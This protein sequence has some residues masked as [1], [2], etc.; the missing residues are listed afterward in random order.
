MVWWSAVSVDGCCS[1]HH[2]PHRSKFSIRNH[3]G[4][5]ELNAEVLDPGAEMRPHLADVTGDGNGDTAATDRFADPVFESKTIESI[6]RCSR[7]DVVSKA[8]ARLPRTLNGRERPNDQ[9]MLHG[10]GGQTLAS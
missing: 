7:I 2:R 8:R 4:D 5:L 10:E 6:S 3:G 1:F 9:V